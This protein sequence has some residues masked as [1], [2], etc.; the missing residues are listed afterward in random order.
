MPTA[1]AASRGGVAARPYL[2]GLLN[3]HD[4]ARSALT[5]SNFV[6]R[7]TVAV[8][9]VC[10]ERQQLVRAALS[11]LFR[12]EGLQELDVFISQDGGSNYTIDL[13]AQAVKF[14]L[15]YLRHPV[16]LCPGQ[17]HYLVKSFVFDIMG[18]ESLIV[19]EE[20]NIVHPD[21][22]KVLR[23][24]LDLTVNDT[25]IGL[26]S[27]NDFDNHLLINTTRFGSTA[28]RVAV[29]LG[30]LW[31]F[32]VHASRYHAVHSDLRDYFNLIIGKDYPNI[33][34]PPLRDEVAALQAAK[35]FPPGMPL[36]QDAF[37]VHSL[38][39]AGYTRRLTTMVRLFEPVGW[40]G[41]HFREDSMH[42]Y[43]YFGRSMFSGRVWEEPR[44]AC[45]TEEE[46]ELLAA[47]CRERLHK[48]YQKHLGRDADEGALDAVVKRLL[49]GEMNT[50]ELVHKMVASEEHQQRH[51]S[52]SS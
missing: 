34:Q 17:H 49:S 30:H 36:S 27:V 14:N 18:Y 32:G 25:Q 45:V 38:Q 43:Q 40:S 8:V 11:A 12:S 22:I 28:L 51:L 29:D 20:D 46:R 15:V 21:A 5:G 3:D 37:F 16:N 42:F 6:K 19:V 39:K 47:E 24:L 52:P 9:Y 13:P 1:E 7:S 26:V 2:E 31:V 33:D 10:F 41:L 23:G 4:A 48:L 35:G 44:E 50:V